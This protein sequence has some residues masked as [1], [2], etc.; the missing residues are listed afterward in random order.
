MASKLNEKK[1]ANSIRIFDL[2]VNKRK[3]VE[4]SI[5]ISTKHEIKKDRGGKFSDFFKFSKDY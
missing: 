5:P 1:I 4:L 3:S 2:V